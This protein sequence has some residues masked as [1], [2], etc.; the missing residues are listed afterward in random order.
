MEC[1]IIM[2]PVNEGIALHT[3]NTLDS[4]GKCDIGQYNGSTPG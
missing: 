4:A 3:G 1:R 2:M